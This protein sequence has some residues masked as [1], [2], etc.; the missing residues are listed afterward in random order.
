MS[1]EKVTYSKAS[2]VSPDPH[3]RASDPRMYSLD[4]K[5][6]PVPPD[7]QS[8]SPRLVL[9]LHVC[10]SDPWNG[11]RTP[12]YGIRVTLSGVPRS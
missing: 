10:K 6:G 11:I 5:D 1:P 4:P 7:I 12:P 3:G 9:D 8:G 2:T